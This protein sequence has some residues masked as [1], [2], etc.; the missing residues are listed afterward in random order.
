[1]KKNILMIC[2]TVYQI[3]VASW[4]KTTLLQRD[5]VDIII[6]DHMNDY[7]KIAE[8]MKKANL[9][10]HVMTV[11]SKAYAYAFER[12]YQT[13]KEEKLC[14]MFPNRELKHYVDLHKRYDALYTS[15]FDTFVQM[16]YDALYRRK[17]SIKLY[18][19]ED[20]LSTYSKHSQM[21]YE[22][23]KLSKE[24]AE[25][26]KACPIFGKRVFYQH[27]EAMYVFNP[28]LVEWSTDFSI[29]QLAHI[30][31]ANAAFKQ[32]MNTVFG[33]ENLEDTYSEKYI[34]F[35]ES[36]YAE[37]GY[38]EDVK[39]V[40]QLASVL[41]K[42]N[43][44]IKIHPRNP[45]NRFAELGYKTNKNT[46]IPWEL[47]AM[48]LDVTSK[49][50]ITISSTSILNPICVLGL[51]TKSYAL[52]NCLENKPDI[53]NGVLGQTALSFYHYYADNICICKNIADVIDKGD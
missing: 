49:K 19:F 22:S 25:K 47:I 51:D 15:N 36:F 53:M 2:N 24:E 43:F 52:I 1:M 48:N 16:L 33:Y 39:L 37:T 3:L 29:Q 32:A 17:R 23:T 31:C 44:L 6:S 8:N 18:I 9:F 7:E 12:H 11:E 27:V 35:E 40:E 50:L 13:E 26:A 20:G 45:E 38:M 34:F 10:N 5:C 4:I 14:K 30:D 28:E 21:L 46:A 42:E 41:G